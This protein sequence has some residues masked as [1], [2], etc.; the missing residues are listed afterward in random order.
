[1]SQGTA[2]M[3]MCWAGDRA[4]PCPPL[5]RW[6]CGDKATV[7]SWQHSLSSEGNAAVT[8]FAT[9]KTPNPFP[10]HWSVQTDGVF[11]KLVESTCYEKLVHGFLKFFCTKI[12]LSR[13]STFPQHS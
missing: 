6:G 1:M 13:N 2:Y 5:L 8:P 9:A 4:L 7:Q 12:D 11:N 10:Q 3:A